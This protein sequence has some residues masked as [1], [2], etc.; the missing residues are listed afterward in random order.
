MDLMGYRGSILHFIKKPV[1]SNDKDSYQY[2]EN[3]ILLV[4]GGKIEAVGH[5]DDL[6]KYFP[7][8]LK[9]TD[10]SDHLIVPGFIDTHIH[11]AQSEIIA[12]YGEQLL[13]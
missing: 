8:N 13:E 4:S 10:Y 5:Y 12:S 6:I 9:I 11:Y 1:S 2:F 7:N 3:G